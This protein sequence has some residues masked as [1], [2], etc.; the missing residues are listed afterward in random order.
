MTTTLTFSHTHAVVFIS[1]H[2]RNLLKLIIVQSRLDPQKLLDAWTEVLDRAVRTWL[3]SRHLIIII[4]E[5]YLPGS[6]VADARW[7]FQIHYDGSGVPE[8]WIDP[9]YLRESIAKAAPAPAGASYRV[10]L[11]LKDGAPEV[12]GMAT[13]SLRSTD[14]LT[15]RDAGT[16]IATSGITT[17]ARYYRR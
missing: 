1:D 13:T 10:V 9:E 12:P 4:I 11:R 15:A 7:D 2:L 8:M 17:S 14:G 3:E 16:V 6:D 5:F